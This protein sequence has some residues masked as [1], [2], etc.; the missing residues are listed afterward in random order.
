ME[1]FLVS[2]IGAG[3][4]GLCVPALEGVVRTSETVL[5]E[6]IPFIVLEVRH[7]G[8]CASGIR[9]VLVELHVVGV[10]FP[11][12]VHAVVRGVLVGEHAG[13]GLGRTACGRIRVTFRFTVVREVQIVGGQVVRVVCL[14]LIGIRL[15]HL[16]PTEELIACTRRRSQNINRLVDSERLVFVDDASF[17]IGVV[18]VPVDVR[19]GGILGGAVLG[20]QLDGVFL[21][22]RV[23]FSGGVFRLRVLVVDPEAVARE[24][25]LVGVDVL[26]AV[27]LL[28]D[29]VLEGKLGL[30]LACRGRL[31]GR[32]GD[33]LSL[34]GVLVGIVRLIGAYHRVAVAVLT[35][36]GVHHVD[37]VGA[38]EDPSPTGIEVDL[39][40]GAGIGGVDLF[41]GVQ[42]TVLGNDGVIH[43]ESIEVPHPGEAL[44]GEPAGQVV[45]VAGAA[46][47]TDLLAVVDPE[48]VMAVRCILASWFVVDV[49]EGLVA[50][51]VGMQRDLVLLEHPLGVYGDAVNGHGGEIVRLCAGVVAVPAEED[52][53]GAIWDQARGIEIVVLVD[54]GS[55]GDGVFTLKGI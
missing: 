40:H 37:A 6:L 25:V 50:V 3:A 4:V 27:P 9:G 16:A 1:I 24:H 14:S 8:H 15:R 35:N 23:I 19:R 36:R 44:V 53:V 55:V 22:V 10:Y 17:A 42:P 11:H 39:A 7:V 13:C 54:I 2:V 51:L 31:G 18:V 26:R 47:V 45:Q 29:P 33:G 49:L 21:G 12:G 43:H 20:A 38:V 28:D 48:V 5:G 32:A 52:V 34:V 46:H 30:A 41:G